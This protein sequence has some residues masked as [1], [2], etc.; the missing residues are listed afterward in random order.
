M[1]SNVASPEKQVDEQSARQISELSSKLKALALK[2]TQDKKQWETETNAL[3]EEKKKELALV[4]AIK[5]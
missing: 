2:Y 1:D 4:G 5:F 3:L